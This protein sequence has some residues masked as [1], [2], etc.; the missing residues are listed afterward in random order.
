MQTSKASTYKAGGSVTRYSPP[1]KHL[2]MCVHR[3]TVIYLFL[4][5]LDLGNSVILNKEKASFTNTTHSCIIKI[6]EVWQPS[7]NIKQPLKACVSEEN[8]EKLHFTTDTKLY[9]SGAELSDFCFLHVRN[10]GQETSLSVPR[11][12]SLWNGG[13]SGTSLIGWLWDLTELVRIKMSTW[14]ILCPQQVLA[15]VII[16][17]WLHVCSR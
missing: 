16:T 4:L 14:H 9:M 1:G 13:N 7:W 11:F 2:A 3:L 8:E 6:R 10:L 5:H 15:V 17:M 12:Y